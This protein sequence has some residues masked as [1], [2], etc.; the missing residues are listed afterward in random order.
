MYAMTENRKGGFRA[1]L[2]YLHDSLLDTCKVWEGTSATDA[3]GLPVPPSG[4]L[5]L[6][7]ETGLI[8]HNLR[9]IHKK[10]EVTVFTSSRAES[11]AYSGTTFADNY[12]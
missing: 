2:R 3:F 9:G 4:R 6:D 7:F 11:R 12:S 1:K 5:S 10:T 8:T